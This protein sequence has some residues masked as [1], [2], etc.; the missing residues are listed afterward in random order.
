MSFRLLIVLLI[1]DA[2]TNHFT[3]NKLL[4]KVTIIRFYN[5][6]TFYVFIDFIWE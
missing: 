4:Q 1:I 6:S 2:S 3:M 5:V